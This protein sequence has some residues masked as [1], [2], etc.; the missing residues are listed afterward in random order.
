LTA[1]STAENLTN[2]EEALTE[3]EAIVERMEKGELTLEQSL[4]QFERGVTLAR[5]CQEA[6]KQAEQ[7]VEMLASRGGTDQAEPLKPDE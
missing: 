4:A 3:L 2:L 7:K 6:L 1:K 5:Q